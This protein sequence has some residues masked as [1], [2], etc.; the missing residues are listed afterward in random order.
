M[1]Q[2]DHTLPNRITEWRT[3]QL[4]QSLSTRTV[5]ERIAAVMRCADQSQ[6]APQN[7]QP[8]QISSWLAAAA[9][10]SLNT[11]WTYYTNLSAWFL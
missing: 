3:W 8:D 2:P 1:T 10:W 11:R 7:L 4:A 5:N 6:T 9:D